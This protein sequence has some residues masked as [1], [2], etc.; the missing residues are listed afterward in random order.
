MG[1]PLSVVLTGGNVND[2]TE[3]G[4]VL[5]GIRVTRPIGRP[6]T[7]PDRVIA[8]KGYSSR[9]NRRMLTDRG[10][11][12]T[13]PERDDQL[14]NR[15]RR[16]S[17]GGRPYTFDATLYRDRNIIERCFGWIKHWRGIASRY[18]KKARNYLGGITLAA[19]LAWA[20]SA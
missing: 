18:D 14:A 19:A 5:A 10:I 13:I 8:D 3:L 9:A 6:R 12:V 7:R 4:D 17:A 20:R 15:R 2:T 16:G 11:R 1:R